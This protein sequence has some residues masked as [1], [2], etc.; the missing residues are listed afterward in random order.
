VDRSTP[1]GAL[2]T[3]VLTAE[4]RTASFMGGYP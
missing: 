4:T 2:P 3:G 1:L